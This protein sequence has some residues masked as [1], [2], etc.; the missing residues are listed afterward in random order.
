[1]PE[2]QLTTGPL[3]K[4]LDDNINFSPDGKV[5]VFDCRGATGINGNDRL[6]VVNV[7]TGKVDIVYRQTPPLLGLGA[8]SFL[9]NHEI[10]A[11]HALASG[12]KYDFTLRAG[13]IIPADGIGPGRWLDSR[14]IT[15]PYTPGALRGGT[16]KHEPDV[17]GQWVGFTYN[18]HIMKTRNGSDLRNMG[19][20]HLG[21]HVAVH[22]DHAGQNIEGESFS[23]LLT[24]CVDHPR[25]GTDDYQR[26]DSDCWVGAQGYRTSHGRQRARAFRGEVIPADGGAAAGDVFIVD[27][28]DDI[29]IP[30]PLGPLQGTDTGYPKPPKGAVVR[31]L[32]HTAASSDPR[33]RG[34]SGHLRADN[35][36]HWIAYLAPVLNSG[37]IEQQVF[38]VSPAS[39]KTAQLSH[40]PGGVTAGPRFSPD[41]RFVVAATQDGRVVAW[42]AMDHHFGA[43][44][45]LTEPTLKAASNL[46]VSPDSRWVAYN[47]TIQ[48]V[49]QIFVVPAP[50][51]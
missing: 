41:G 28:P 6:G 43:M 48:G 39:G 25:P 22:P 37:V 3:Q 18:D 2:R 51:L 11:I 21:R 17:S 19:V 31:R 36:G 10:I 45:A 42:S 35:D 5:L 1:M 14:D 47:R 16:H 38:I 9:N 27:V 49:L 4:D 12:I 46:V 29:T 8:P 40:I 26:A 30:G 13:R 50:S 32:T 7:E 44:T 15:S 34:I 24:A 20:S 23:V 33:L